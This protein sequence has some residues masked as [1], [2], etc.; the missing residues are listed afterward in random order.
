MKGKTHNL[1]I[2][3]SH[4]L[5]FCVTI[6]F[7]SLSLPQ[8]SLWSQELPE[9]FEDDLSLTDGDIF[10]DFSEDIESSQVLEDERYYR[11]GRFFSVSFSVGFTEFTGNRGKEYENEPPTYGLSITYFFDF[12]N[13][14]VLG[15]GFSKHNFF[16]GYRSRAFANF[17]LGLVEVN[18]F[19]SFFGFR[20]YID[21]ADLGTALTYANPYMA[22]RG[23]YWYQTN[24]FID[25]TSVADQRGGGF[26]V[27]LGGGFEFPIKLKESYL[28]VEILYHQVNFFDSDTLDYRPSSAEEA[29]GETG[30]ENLRGDVITLMISY[31]LSW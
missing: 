24:K 1:I 22:I 27:G 21:T 18:M 25:Q 23:E 8:T 2:T 9:V 10:T 16:V 13:A 6:L 19:R 28:G 14:F 29:A 20:H 17:D 31:V 15:F 11:Y 4:K 7:F 12:Q 5:I 3:Y 30:I 26:G